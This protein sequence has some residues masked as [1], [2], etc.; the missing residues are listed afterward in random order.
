MV[1]AWVVFF[2]L[3]WGRKKE[4]LKGCEKRKNESA[5]GHAL[6]VIME[7]KNKGV[8]VGTLHKRTHGD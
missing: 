7:L 6:E 2:F 5:S 4:K 1:C 3:N 8:K